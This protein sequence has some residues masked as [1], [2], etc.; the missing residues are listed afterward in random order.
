MINTYKIA[1]ADNN[2][3]YSHI[4]AGWL[5]MGL[6]GQLCLCDEAAAVMLLVCGLLGASAPRVSHPASASQD[7]VFCCSGRGKHKAS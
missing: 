5:G 4:R 6:A 1:V 7:L 2:K 3:H